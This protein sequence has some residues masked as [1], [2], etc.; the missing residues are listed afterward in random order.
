MREE[1]RTFVAQDHPSLT[2]EEGEIST[3]VIRSDLFLLSDPVI[4]GTLLRHKTSHY[5]IRSIYIHFIET[6]M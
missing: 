4:K 6:A 3:S 1:V 2:W 5:T